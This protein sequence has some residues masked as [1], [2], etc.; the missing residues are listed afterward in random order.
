MHDSQIDLPAETTLNIYSPISDLDQDDTADDSSS[1][2]FVVPE[3]MQIDTYDDSE[4]FGWLDDFVGDFDD[5]PMMDYLEIYELLDPDWLH[6]DEMIPMSNLAQLDD[7]AV[8]DDNPWPT[9]EEH[10]KA[11]RQLIDYLK[12]AIVP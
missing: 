10:D 12:E 7:C 9:T 5:F 3:T 1:D 2:D 6:R 11:I 4:L 8:S